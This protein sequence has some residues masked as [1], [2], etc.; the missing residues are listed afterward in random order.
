MRLLGAATTG[1][2]ALLERPVLPLPHLSSFRPRF[3][4]FWFLGS[5]SIRTYV[6]AGMA[7]QLDGGRGRLAEAVEAVKDNGVGALHLAAGGKKAQVCEFLVEDV[8]VDV[9]AVDMCGVSAAL[10]IF[11]LTPYRD[12]E[13]SEYMHTQLYL[14]VPM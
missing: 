4:Q 2:L 14:F 8:R 13:K 9:D 12:I 10:A 1:D 11:L 5:R 7:I 3:F 6:R